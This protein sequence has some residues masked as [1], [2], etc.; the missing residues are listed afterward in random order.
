MILG[1]YIL[2]ESD[3][4]IQPEAEQVEFWMFK[5]LTGVKYRAK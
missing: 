3:K 2:N 5:N 4:I 1:L